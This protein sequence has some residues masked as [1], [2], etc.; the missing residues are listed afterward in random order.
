MG[1][2]QDDMSCPMS[3]SKHQCK[4]RKRK[5]GHQIDYLRKVFELNPDWDKHMVT[6]LSKKTGLSENQVY[7]W[8]WD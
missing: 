5:S 2:M 7:K 8:G 4:K 6:Q 1:L 3:G